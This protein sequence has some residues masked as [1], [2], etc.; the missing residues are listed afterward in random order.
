MTTKIAKKKTQKC[1]ANYHHTPAENGF[2]NVCRAM[3]HDSGLLYFDGR[4]MVK[5]FRVKP[6]NGLSKD[7]FYSLLKSLIDTGWYEQV[8]PRRRNPASG[9]WMAGVYRVL[10][11]DEWIARFG[12][13]QC[14]PNNFDA[15]PVGITGHAPVVTAGLVPV[16]IEGVSSR[17]KGIHLSGEGHSPVVTAGHNLIVKSEKENLKEKQSDSTRP[18]S[19]TLAPVGSNGS[20]VAT[21]SAIPY[22]P[23]P[24]TV[25]IHKHTWGCYLSG[26][27][28][29][30][31]GTEP[32]IKQ[33]IA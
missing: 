9:F 16:G 25:E 28:R 17:E 3:S 10:S 19:Y 15:S 27:L 30:T 21:R 6:R 26:R 5:H 29:C 14:F 33:E 31:L 2:W 8:E 22:V 12:K 18:P 1:H 11:H 20:E 7:Y 32:L 24:P 4:T 13:D 23:L